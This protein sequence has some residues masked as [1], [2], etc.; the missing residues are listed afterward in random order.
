MTMSSLLLHLSEHKKPLVTSEQ[1][2]ED[3]REHPQILLPTLNGTPIDSS[4]CSDERCQQSKYLN[5]Q[6]S[7]A[8][9]CRSDFFGV[10]FGK[11]GE[12]Q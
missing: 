11:E 6:V 3:F 12:P 5:W 10:N 1:S 2:I 4:L 7:D 9:V 8:S